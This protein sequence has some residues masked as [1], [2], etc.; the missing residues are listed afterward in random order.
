MEFNDSTKLQEEKE[1]KIGNEYYKSGKID[2][3]IKY[4]TRSLAYNP[5]NCITYSNRG[6]AYL[7]INKFAEA[8][9]D[10]SSA[11]KLSPNHVKSLLRRGTARKKM[12]LYETAYHDFSKVLEI[13]PSNLQAISECDSVKNIVEN[14]KNNIQVE[15]DSNFEFKKEIEVKTTTSPVITSIKKDQSSSNHKSNLL[16]INNKKGENYQYS[17]KFQ[18]SLREIKTQV[19]EKQPP[20][21]FYEFIQ[22]WKVLN[23][24]RELQYRFLIFSLGPNSFKR[25][26]SRGTLEYELFGEIIESLIYGVKLDSTTSGKVIEILCA[27]TQSKGFKMILSFLCN[28]DRL[29]LKNLFDFLSCHNSCKNEELSRLRSI[30]SIEI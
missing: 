29:Q 17:K 8:E 2:L 28:N 23:N 16:S 5:R 7:K 21:S 27:I 1:R 19:L 20:Q 15:K 10:C 30:F 24:E 13:E 14:I 18:D 11:L 22:S 9:K 25:I 12:G 3:A 4:Y 6:L 26:F